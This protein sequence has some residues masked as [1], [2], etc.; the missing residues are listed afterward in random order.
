M[1]FERGRHHEHDR[2]AA[3]LGG[4]H[5]RA[6]GDSFDGVEW[7]AP[8]GSVGTPPQSTDAADAMHALL[9]LR[10]DKLAG[11]SERSEEEAELEMITN[12]VEA[13]EVVRW[14]DGKVDGGKG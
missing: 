6:V 10:G 11:C 4:P 3:H 7:A 13:Y 2:Q 1:R 9:V 5:A 8:A 12:A 14:S